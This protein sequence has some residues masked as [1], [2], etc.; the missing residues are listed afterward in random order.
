MDCLNHHNDAHVSW[1]FEPG[2]FTLSLGD[3][4]KAGNEV[5]NNYGP[6]S[7]AEL[8]MGYGFCI[9]NNAHDAV[10]EALKPPPSELLGLIRK[11]HPGYIKT[12]GTWDSDAATFSLSEWRED[13]GKNVWHSI[14]IPL[15]ELFYYMVLYE[16]GLAVSP[17]EGDVKTFL[18][19]GYGSRCLPR[20]AF[21]IFSSLLPKITKI[22]D[23]SSH[24]SAGPQ[25]QKQKYAQIYRNGQLRILNSLRDGLL[26][27]QRS[28]R[29]ESLPLGSN[30]PSRP[31]ILSLEDAI[32]LLTVHD[33][34]SGQAFTKGIEHAFDVP[35]I[36]AVWGTGIEQQLWILYLCYAMVVV[37][38]TT[39]GPEG[40]AA[41]SVL[42]AQMV[43]LVREYGDGQLE[44]SEEDADSSDP[45]GQALIGVVRRAAASVTGEDNSAWRS[46][47]WT[48][49]FILDWGLRIAT[50]QGMQMR[51]SDDAVRHVLYLHVDK[52]EDEQ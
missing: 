20:I 28:L 17:I 37:F 6:K 48:C 8:L 38:Q 18:L 49:S 52:D 12:N 3:D 43:S 23:A 26:R 15:I 41:D 13:S 7:N 44:I 51:L 5:F 1:S 40:V 27:F 33:A 35:A 32:H 47:W 25:N 11:I 14:P 29:P 46:K 16:R 21:L 39:T 30:T 24:L 2:R 34:A 9:E 45:E 42:R 36:S 4:T 50:S 31:Y 22:N 10:L 19:E